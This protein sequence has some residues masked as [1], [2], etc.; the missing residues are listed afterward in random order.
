MAQSSGKQ[1][2]GIIPLDKVGNILGKRIPGGLPGHGRPLQPDFN[3]GDLKD[4]RWYNDFHAKFHSNEILSIEDMVKQIMFFAELEFY[5][6]TISTSF[7]PRIISVGTTAVQITQKARYP[8][9]YIFLNP[10]EVSG[11]TS[12]FTFYSSA[13]RADGFN[14]PSASVNVSGIN[15]VRTFLD[16]T[17]VTATPTLTI[18]AQ[19]Q[20]SLSGN[21][22]TAQFDIFT[23]LATVGTF[24]VSLGTIGVD[25]IIRLL[26]TV[27]NAGGDDITFSISGLAKGGSNAPVGS[28][29]FIGDRDVNTTMG[30]RVLP[31]Q[32]RRFYLLPNVELFAITSLDSLNFMVWELQ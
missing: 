19:T 28:T 24:Y 11:V 6:N 3:I 26:A 20:D 7:L 18:D 32:E 21:F 14:T 2:P 29:V 17:A 1:V 8:K 30:I 4:S 10:A 9:A 12:S 5:L 15:T 16:I 23:T 27:G 25:R 13:L 22:A 31:T